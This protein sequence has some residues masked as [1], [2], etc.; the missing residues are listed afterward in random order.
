MGFAQAQTE[1]ICELCPTYE[2]CGES[3][4]FCV[5]EAGTSKCI[6][7]DNGCVCPGC[8]VAEKL[9]MKRDYYCIRG[10]EKAQGG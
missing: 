5:W 2:S 9:R 7:K 4:A 6:K 10:S 8:A 3:L 1:C